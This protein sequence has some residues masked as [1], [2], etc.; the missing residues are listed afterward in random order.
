MRLNRSSSQLAQG[1]SFNIPPEAY[2]VP[3]IVRLKLPA[4]RNTLLPA[5]FGL[6]DG[7]RGFE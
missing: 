6:D 1:A 5:I 2:S 3:L 7:K 4:E